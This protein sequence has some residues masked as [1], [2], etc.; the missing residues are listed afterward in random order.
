MEIFLALAHYDDLVQRY[1][2]VKENIVLRA[3]L[4]EKPAFLMQKALSLT[5]AVRMDLFVCFRDREKEQELGGWKVRKD[6]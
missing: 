3:L 5:S 1:P 4:P 2:E 6:L